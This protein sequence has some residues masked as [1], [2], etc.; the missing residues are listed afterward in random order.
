MALP[1]PTK[2]PMRGG[3]EPTKPTVPEPQKATNPAI[4]QFLNAQVP[5]AADL[6]PPPVSAGPFAGLPPAADEKKRGRP[7]KEK[8]EPPAATK[9]EPPAETKPEHFR[10]LT[11]YIGAIPSDAYVTLDEVLREVELE[12]SA[13]REERSGEHYLT[14]P[15]NQGPARVA[16]LFEMKF[17]QL[18]QGVVAVVVFPRHPAA[19]SCLEIL[20]PRA[21]RV[22][23]GVI[24]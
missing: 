23:Y 13:K 2:Q 22:V 18:L 9:P 10:D 20:L 8:P 11:V 17:E 7:R 14:I 24:G 6:N 5:G 12:V 21:S 16:A 4:D 19:A 3:F 15:Y 1:P